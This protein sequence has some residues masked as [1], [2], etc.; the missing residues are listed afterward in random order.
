MSS[1]LFRTMVS[2]EP[3]QAWKS[4]RNAPH[5]QHFTQNFFFHVETDSMTRETQMDM[6]CTDQRQE[7][8]KGLICAK[9]SCPDL[10]AVNTRHLLGTELSPKGKFTLG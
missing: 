1:I 9:S 3:P 8:T 4:S 7:F 6:G 5:V 10:N 2:S